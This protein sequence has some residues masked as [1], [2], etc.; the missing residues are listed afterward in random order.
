MK[1]ASPTLFRVPAAV[2]PTSSTLLDQFKLEK[3]ALP[4]LMKSHILFSS[5]RASSNGS[6]GFPESLI[7]LHRL[8]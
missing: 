6:G 3:L 8:N 1:E 4:A 2:F 7:H 5:A